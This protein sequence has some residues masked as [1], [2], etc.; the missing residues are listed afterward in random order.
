MLSFFFPSSY[1]ITLI[2]CL[3]LH[4]VRKVVPDMWKSQ[5]YQRFWASTIILC[6]RFA[7]GTCYLLDDLRSTHTPSK[8]LRA[9]YSHIYMCYVSTSYLLPVYPHNTTCVLT[10]TVP[11]IHS[12]DT[13]HTLHTIR[14]S[15][16]HTIPI[17]P[18]IHTTHNKHMKHKTFWQSQ[19]YLY[20]V[21][22][23]FHFLQKAVPR[24]NKFELTTRP[25][26]RHAR[27]PQKV[28]P[29]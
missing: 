8:Y 16:I 21:T 6:E 17:L 4:F 13:I 27:S 3:E 11:T 2:C 29:A 1:N 24:P 5:F 12:N 9:T 28:A 18:I 15:T 10:Y 22:C 23:A 26:V 20:F 7:P 25:D 14:T 19:F